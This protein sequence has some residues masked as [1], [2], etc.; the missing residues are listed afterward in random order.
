MCDIWRPIHADINGVLDKEVG[1]FII[2]REGTIQDQ[3]VS[4]GSQVLDAV[5]IRYGP[6]HI[7]IKMTPDGPRL[8]EIAAR[9]SGSDCPYHAEL[10]IGESQL[11][12]TVDAYV[13]PEQFNRRYQDTYCIHHQV[14]FVGMLSPYTGILR[15]YPYLSEVERLESL[16]ELYVVIKPGDPIVRSIPGATHPMI[17]ILRHPVEEVVLRDMQTL[18]YL[19][20][21]AFYEL[22]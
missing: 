9:L 3:L 19:D 18:R 11:N 14:G 15:S 22:E 21:P 2:P 12:W 13:K 4:Y 10:A 16:Y 1:D 5:G 20:G 7:E 8:V 6:A 17:A